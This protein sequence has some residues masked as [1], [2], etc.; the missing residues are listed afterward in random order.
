MPE[1][2]HSGSFKLVFVLT[3]ICEFEEVIDKVVHH[4]LREG[5]A[6]RKE[7][8]HEV[9]SSNAVRH[10]TELAES[11]SCVYHVD[12][13]LGKDRANDC[14]LPCCAFLYKRE[15]ES[16]EEGFRLEHCLFHCIIEMAIELLIAF[17]V[18]LDG[19]EQDEVEEPLYL[20]LILIGDEDPC[21]FV[22]GSIAPFFRL[23]EKED[24]LPILQLRNELEDFWQLSTFVGFENFTHCSIY[25]NYFRIHSTS[26]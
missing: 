1:N 17:N 24:I 9:A 13:A 20:L 16:L 14:S 6:L 12:G 3:L 15:N 5:V 21:C 19:R 23:S 11:C 26:D 18:V 25:F 10:L 4:S 8:L 7:D 2:G 22:H